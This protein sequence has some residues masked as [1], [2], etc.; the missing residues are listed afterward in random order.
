MQ[1][2]M[3]LPSPTCT[4]FAQQPDGGRF[5]QKTKYLQLT[6]IPLRVEHAAYVFTISPARWLQ[7]QGRAKAVP[8]FE[9]VTLRFLVTFETNRRE[10]FS[11]GQLEQWTRNTA[12]SGSKQSA[13]ISQHPQSIGSSRRSFGSF[14]LPTY[15]T[16]CPLKSQD[17]CT[18]K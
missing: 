1:F 13:T 3:T 11:P 12:R 7:K 14:T 9:K 2:L 10:R 16:T 4:P 18:C 8:L 15:T 6:G 17:H 5:T